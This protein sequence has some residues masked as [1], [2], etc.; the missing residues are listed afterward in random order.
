MLQPQVP[1]WNGFTG[2]LGIDEFDP[3]LVAQ[4]ARPNI[5]ASSRRC[6][7][8]RFMVIKVVLWDYDDLISDFIPDS[9]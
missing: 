1:P 5:E 4:E 8:S 3:E 7:K 9:M 6:A 2:E